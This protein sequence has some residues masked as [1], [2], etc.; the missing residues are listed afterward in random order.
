LFSSE[1]GKIDHD[2]CAVQGLT[3]FDHLV[4]DTIQDLNLEEE[5]RRIQLGDAETIVLDG[6]RIEMSSA[7]VFGNHWSQL[8]LGWMMVPF[9]SETQRYYCQYS[10]DFGIEIQQA[11]RNVRK[12]GSQLS[13]IFKC[14]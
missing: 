9:P 1:V 2:P 3:D 11:S 8:T 6:I 7:R 5:V 14:F 12:K 13:R 4:E 10:P